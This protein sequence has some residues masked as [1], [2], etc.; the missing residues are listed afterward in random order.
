MKIGVFCEPESWHGSDLVRAAGGHHEITFHNIQRLNGRLEEG[1]R[2][3][4]VLCGG[5]RLDNLDAVLVRTIPAGTLDQ[6]VF[7][8]DA[9]AELGRCGVAVVNPARTVEACVDKYLALCLLARAGIAV[10]ETWVCQSRE[11]GLLAFEKLGRLAVLKPVFGSEGRGLLLLDH[12]DLAERALDLLESQ[13][14]TIYL[15]QFIDHS[16]RDIRLFAAGGELRA[17]ERWNPD[18][19]RVNA[20]RGGKTAPH[21]PDSRESALAA[22]ICGVLGAVVAGIDLVYDRS[23]QPYV[24]EVNS[25]PGWKHLSET[26]GCDIAALVLQAVESAAGA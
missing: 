3:S 8:M 9:L 24:L 19:W 22:R 17:M 12:V 5:T 6:I 21:R 16:N 14:Q 26:T 25:A 10:P 20:A 1:G 18:D 11:D 15:Q 7:R 13:G 23:G 4:T 2:S